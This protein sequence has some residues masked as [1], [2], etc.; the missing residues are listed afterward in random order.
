ME[1]FRNLFKSIFTKKENFNVVEV[2]YELASDYINHRLLKENVNWNPTINYNA[3][4]SL[5]RAMRTVGDLLEQYL[6]DIFDELIPANIIITP[7]T[8]HSIFR[9]ICDELFRNGI[10][11]SRIAALYTF[12]GGFTVY[13]SKKLHFTGIAE[14]AAEWTSSYVELN[15]YSWIK[16]HGGWQSFLNYCTMLLK[17]RFNS[18]PKTVFEEMFFIRFQPLIMIGAIISGRVDDV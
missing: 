11:W 3:P 17:K 8:A 16:D 5:C 18:K 1:L 4:T 12:A 10:T 6:Y 2:P 7:I 15:L 13:C 14:C 9:L